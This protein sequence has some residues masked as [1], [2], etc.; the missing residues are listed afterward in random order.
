MFC[1][2]RPEHHSYIE[3]IVKKTR[4]PG[5]VFEQRISSDYA[6]I[7]AGMLLAAR[8]NNSTDK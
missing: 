2:K 4:A 8:E 6:A 1:S 7:I 5:A 3:N